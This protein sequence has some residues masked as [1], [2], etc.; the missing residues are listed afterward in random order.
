MG[1]PLLPIQEDV[2]SLPLCD[3]ALTLPISFC[4]AQVCKLSRHTTIGGYEQYQYGCCQ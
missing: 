2:A 1:E 3:K 4:V